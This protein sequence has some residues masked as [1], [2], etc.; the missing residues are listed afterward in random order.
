MQQ[1]L[2]DAPAADAVADVDRGLG[3]I[4]DVGAS[5]GANL[6]AQL[7][8]DLRD[9]ADRHQQVDDWLVELALDAGFTGMEDLL[10][11][12][13]SVEQKQVGSGQQ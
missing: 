10:D 13:H 4:H 3:Y 1:R 9:P 11:Q 8:L 2:A 12:Y 7:A 6:L 5:Q